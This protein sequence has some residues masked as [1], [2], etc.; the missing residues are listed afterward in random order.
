M[1]EPPSK[2]MKVNEGPLLN[3]T[4]VENLPR[5]ILCIIFSYL[6][7]KY[8][9]NVT[10]TCKLWFELIRS[11][12]NFSSCICLKAFQNLEISVARWPVLKTIK[13]CG[14]YPYF[15]IM[16]KLVQHT[17][18]LAKSNDCPPLE[19]IVVSVSYGLERFFPQ[20]PG[21]GTIGEFTFNP[22]D[23][24]TSLQ[25]E[26][27]TKLY[28]KFYKGR[29]DEIDKSEISS[30][31]KLIGDTACNLKDINIIAMY[32]K[33]ELIDCFQD[34]FGQMLQQL[35]DS[36]QRV[37]LEVNIFDDLKRFNL[38][39]LCEQCKKLRSFH[40]NVSFHYLSDLDK[41]WIQI[42][43]P[44]QIEKIFQDFTDVKIQ[45]YMHKRYS[46]KRKLCSISKEPYQT[47]T[48]ILK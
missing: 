43:F 31:L 44:E 21:S 17:N 39:K 34:S 9:Q 41:D 35:T 47:T 29:Y 7:K 13:F 37:K 48:V 25:V 30:S 5:E 8:V 6:D 46:D 23:G 38:P 3:L 14:N 10:A 45:F 36:L 24:I 40:I 32:E 26:Q 19:K 11:D 15:S 22:K 20:F 33:H 12:L 18:K 2:K 28:L 16:E 27:M 1:E 4:R 42:E